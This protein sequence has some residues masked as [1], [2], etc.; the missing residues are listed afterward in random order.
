MIRMTATRALSLIPVLLGIA[1]IAFFLIRLIPGSVVNIV[2]GENFNNPALAAALK[3]F[4]GL[5]E[6]LP[7]QFGSWFAGLL[8][9]NLGRSLT[10]GEPVTSMVLQR[11]PITLELSVAALLI[12]LIVSIPLGI[13]AA[14]HRS[15][16]ADALARVGSLVGLSVPGFWLGIM[17]ILLFSVGTHT[18]PA[19]GYAP[20][21]FSWYH[22]RYL[23]LPS[24]TLG[25]SLAAV[26][27]RM[28]RSS[29][30]EVQGL[31]YVRTARAKG[32]RERSILLHH[33][34]RN[35]LIPVVTVLGIQVG[36]LLG[37]TIIVEQVFSWPGLG[38]LLI[39]AIQDRD[40]PLVQ[41]ITIFLAFFFVVAN[42]IVD[43]LYGL[44][45]PR[46]RRHV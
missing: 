18:F 10:T 46:I 39:Q 43:V 7:R 5:D 2:L 36:T 11:F 1:V 42:F 26:T 13:I 15:K 6:S 33:E 29:L 20:F 44:L 14:R 25:L 23:V 8:H 4:F 38:M 30:L 24:V 37:G 41:G 21:S 27:T 16:G 22:F 3:R 35:A 17:L 9:G 32:L 34:L 28:T 45:D 19:S 40:Y 12:S 31:E